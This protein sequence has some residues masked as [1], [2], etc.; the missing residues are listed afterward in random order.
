[1]SRNQN[2]LISEVF[3]RPKS[4][5]SHIE[6]YHDDDSEDD[7][8]FTTDF[9]E[10]KIRKSRRR[11]NHFDASIFT[12][13]FIRTPFDNG[14]QDQIVAKAK[15][16][17]QDKYSPNGVFRPTPGKLSQIQT[18]DVFNNTDPSP[19]VRK[20]IFK[21]WSRRNNQFIKK[22]KMRLAVLGFISSENIDVKTIAKSMNLQR[23]QIRSILSQ[24]LNPQ[25][26]LQNWVKSHLR[27]L[28]MSDLIDELLR[29]NSS[30]IS[31]ANQ[32]VKYIQEEKPDAIY[33]R[34]EVYK[35]MHLRGLTYKTHVFRTHEINSVKTSR[36]WFIKEYVE[37]L[38][39]DF[40][41][42]YYMDW[43]SFSQQNF[44]KKS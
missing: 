4:L 13:M 6:Y 8:A 26:R 37:K 42:V 24:I 11:N 44:K 33:P 22:L 41:A 5:P 31:S 20:G 21:F 43:T 2:T 1:M 32:V 16:L 28:E 7:L 30:T 14:L 29:H 35:A 18:I 25:N 27:Q 10:R 17:I 19:R 34:S 40:V 3:V 39:Y 38:S 23:S 15:K 9:E 12:P 36:Q